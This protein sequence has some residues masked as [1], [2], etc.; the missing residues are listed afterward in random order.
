MRMLFHCLL[1]I[2]CILHTFFYKNPVNK[3]HEAQ[4]SEI[5]RTF[6]RITLRLN[7]STRTTHL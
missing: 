4:I 6:L 3:N 2:C 7:L 5:L 1:V